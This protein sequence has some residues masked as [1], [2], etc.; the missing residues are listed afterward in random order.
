MAA[1]TER[2][3]SL[4]ILRFVA[5][6]MVVAFHATCLASG[7]A[8]RS[9]ANANIGAAGVDIFFVLSG[10]VI[11]L[12]GPLASPRPSGAMFFWRRWRRVAPIYYILTLPLIAAAA[13]AGKLDGSKLIA[14][15]LF[16]PAAGPMVVT[17]YLEAGWTLG[18]EMIFYSA[19]ALALI[20]GRLRRN[21]LF[22]V[23]TLGAIIVGW[24]LTGWSSV[25][26]LASPAL[27]EFAT[28]AGLAALWPWL[29][30]ANVAFGAA[31][32][33][34]SLGLFAAVALSGAASVIYFRY[35]LDPDYNGALLRVVLCGGP[36]A[37]LVAGAAICNRVL[38]GRAAAA[39]GFLGDASYSTY[40]THQ[41][42]L[43]FLAPVA[44]LAVGEHPLAQAALL[45]VLALA[46]R[47]LT[48]V[49]IERP[50]LRDL[51]RLSVP[52]PPWRPAAVETPT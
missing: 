30:R 48:Y 3:V 14:T 4:Q 39:L 21:L 16:W 34:L 20:G 26:I 15:F 1:Q 24:R 31:L 36:A 52:W 33:G 13:W 11:A 51:K 46:V 29:R 27:I 18:F 10:F 22:I 42:A 35:A 8:S 28:G 44:R 43:A 17:P 38:A 25:R 45:I 6:A 19:V 40:L 5:A 9:C 50:I 7:G 2:I 32:T 41:M 12:T 49:M 37:L 47:A 23:A